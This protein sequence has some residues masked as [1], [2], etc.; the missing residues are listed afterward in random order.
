MET[1]VVEAVKKLSIVQTDILAN[2]KIQHEHL[3][4]MNELLDRIVVDQ[5]RMAISIS[6]IQEKIHGLVSVKVH[7]TDGA[8]IARG[9]LLADNKSD[10]KLPTVLLIGTSN[11][12]NI[13]GDKLTAFARITKQVEYTLD[14]TYQFITSNINTTIPDLVVLHPFTNDIKKHNPQQCVEK[15]EHIVHLIQQEWDSTRIIISLATPR[16]DD[17]SY[18]TNGQILNALVKQQLHGNSSV[19]LIDHSYMLHD[20]NPQYGLLADDGFHLSDK[21]VSLLAANIKRAIHKI[22]GIQTVRR[23]RSRSR[24]SRE[25]PRNA[26]K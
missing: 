14:D 8:S 17:I 10:P 18:H 12:K 21:G 22:L 13:K 26:L 2:H 24:T 23:S 9:P 11:I 1:S 7:N 3:T 25:T 15:L 19:S 20:G 16:T 6:E 4:R 5:H